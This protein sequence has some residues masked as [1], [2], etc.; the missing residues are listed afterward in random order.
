LI[1]LFEKIAP[2]NENISDRSLRVC[3]LSFNSI[4]RK[5]RA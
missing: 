1:I 3:R 5:A 4:F 2:P